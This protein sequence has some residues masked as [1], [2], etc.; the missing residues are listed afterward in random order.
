MSNAAPRTGSRYRYLIEASLLLLNIGLGMSFLSPA[1][2]FT[3]IIEAFQI[4]RATVSLLIG[5]PS[6]SIAILL[7]PASIVAAKLGPRLSLLIGGSLISTA[8]FAP[9][10]GNFAALAAT[11]VAFAC[12]ATLVLSAT[13]AVVMRW[14]VPRELPIVN[15]L[16]VMGQSIGIMTAMF[17]APRIALSIGW[18]AAFFTFG[19]VAAVATAFWL[20]V[21]RTSADASA[22]A[23]APFSIRALPAM[24]TDRPTVL[25]GIGVAGALGT[26]I[27]FTSWLPT[28]WQEA[29]GFSLEQAG[30]TAALLSGF[31]IVGSA[32]GST[33]PSRFPRRR[34][35]LIVSGVLLP[36][37]AVGCFALNMPVVLLVSVAAFGVLGWVFMPI[38][39]TIPMELPNMT[40]ERVGVAIAMV[41]SAANLAGFVFPLLVGFLRDLTGGFTVALSLCAVLGL[42]LAGAGYLMPETGARPI[43]TS[44][45]TPVDTVEATSV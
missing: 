34:P 28:Y 3:Q 20:L 17:L 30:T 19:A 6:L 38:V 41:L 25:L 24:L 42:A 40:A 11:R 5:I 33:L 27:T 45:L 35:F 43:D 22:P 29:F 8:M 13:P 14:F 32:L 7:V 18:A 9:L 21:G 31:G 44:T 16:N 2:L 1:P 4:D 10:A 26:F 36:V 23:A 15:G 37:F 39:F 12:G